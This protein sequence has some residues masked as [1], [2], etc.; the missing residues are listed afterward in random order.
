VGPRRDDEQRLVADAED[1]RLADRPH[2]AADRGRG[3][4]GGPR[5]GRELPGV[6]EAGG[7][8][9][10]AVGTRLAISSPVSGK[11]QA[12][13]LPPSLTS[14]SGSSTLQTPSRALGQ[15]VWNRQAGG[16]FVGDG[17]SP[18]STWRCFSRARRGSG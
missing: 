16:G 13:M 11:W 15:R 10:A 12:A 3:V 18:P 9:A 5:T 2:V 14:S 17:T 4:G 7:A 6:L 8:H 1:E